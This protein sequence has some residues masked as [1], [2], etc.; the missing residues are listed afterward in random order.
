MKLIITGSEGNI[1]RRLRRAFPGCIGI[2][3]AAGAEIRADLSI[4]D[5][6]DPAI[7]AVLRGADALIHLATSAD[8][9]APE[10]VHWQAVVDAARLFAACAAHGVG[11]IVVASSDWAAP[12]NGA[13]INSYGRSKLALESLAAMY[14]AG[15]RSA[16]VI[17]VGWVP[18]DPAELAAA[19][20]WLRRNCWDDDRL[21]AEF[22]R[23]LPIAEQ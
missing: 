17:R 11:R 16:R 10:A 9:D 15:Q 12:K 7:A 21:A 14:A 6:G 5:Y 22:R 3:R 19:P 18:H 4:V 23:A 8:P 1:G 20:D 13:A 2:D